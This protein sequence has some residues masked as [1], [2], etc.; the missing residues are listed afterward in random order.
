MSNLV[1]GT[2]NPPP[3]AGVMCANQHGQRYSAVFAC[4]KPGSRACSAC[5]LVKYCSAECQKAHWTKGHKRDCKNKLNTEAWRP[6]WLRERRNPTFVDPSAGPGWAANAQFGRG[7]HLWGNIPGLDVLN[8]SKN[9]GM[10]AAKTRDFA[11]AFAA[12]GDLRSTIRTINELPSDYSGAISVLL[13]DRNPY[14]MARNL[15]IILILTTLG[16]QGQVSTELACEYALHV[17][18]STFLPQSYIDVITSLLPRLS[19]ISKAPTTPVTLSSTS[20]LFADLA[21]D[22]WTVIFS[23]MTK[24]YEPADASKAFNGVMNTPFRVDYVH[25]FYA[26]L[27]PGHRAAFQKWRTAGIVLP[28]GEVDTH[29]GIPNAWL[30]G[31]D[32]NGQLEFNLSDSANPLRGWNMSD[33]LAAGK[34]HSVPESDIIGATFF[35]IKDQLVEFATRLRRFNVKFVLTDKDAL[36]LPNLLASIPSAPRTFDRIEVSNITD[37][38]YCKVAPVLSAFGPLLNSSN[39]HATLIALFMN[40]TTDQHAGSLMFGSPDNPNFGGAFAQMKQQLPKLSAKLALDTASDSSFGFNPQ[41][42][43]N[44]LHIFRNADAFN[45]SSKEFLQYLSR[46]EA[47]QAAKRVGLKMRLVNTIAPPRRHVPLG[48]KHNV[49][50]QV[51]D[52]DEWYKIACLDDSTY[53]ERYVEWEKAT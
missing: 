15:T 43:P 19:A 18:Y 29:F 11:L 12:C 3:V 21:H 14:I 44:M 2:L 4:E 10:D 31:Q 50:V 33:I 17:W 36:Q 48:S 25:R 46:F 47:P 51:R 53:A 37:S 22:T 27:K 9:E 40:W 38:N 35:Y 39:P 32:D 30:F 23:T 34:T 26:H 6:D 49:I 16:D 8:L 28:H 5:K 45:E 42:H 24:I 7:M 41:M 1:R 20:T 52:E 13:N